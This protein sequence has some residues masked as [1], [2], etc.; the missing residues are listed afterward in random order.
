MI[1]INF[2]PNCRQEVNAAIGFE[3]CNATLYKVVD[4]KEVHVDPSSNRVAVLNRGG[5]WS[6]QLNVTV[7]ES[8]A[9]Y[10]AACAAT[11]HY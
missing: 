1:Q 3:Y 7:Y 5:Q 11:G 4:I 6:R 10:E 9:A 8:M 2:G